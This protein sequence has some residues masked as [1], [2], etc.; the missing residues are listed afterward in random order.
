MPGGKLAIC[1]VPVPRN[2]LFGAQFRRSA[3]NFTPRSSTYFLSTK[4][5]AMVAFVAALTPSTL[6]RFANKNAAP[7]AFEYDGRTAQCGP[8]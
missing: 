2:G 8:Q 4:I 1:A 5:S 7:A 6:V 3:A